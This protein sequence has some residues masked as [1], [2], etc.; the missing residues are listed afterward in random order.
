MI[1][2]NIKL[3]NLVQKWKRVKIEDLLKYL[4]SKKESPE[5]LTITEQNTPTKVLF[6]YSDLIGM[7]QCVDIIVQELKKSRGRKN[8]KMDPN[9]REI[10]QR[11]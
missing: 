8:E 10:P 2:G 11:T 7:F 9:S 5:I 1:D 6:P 3:T 4:S